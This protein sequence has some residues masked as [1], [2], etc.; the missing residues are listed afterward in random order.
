MKRSYIVLA[1]AML[2]ASAACADELAIYGIVDAGLA[3]YAKVGAGGGKAALLKLDTGV[4]QS[5]RLGLKGGEDL[6]AGQRAF[7]VVETGFTLD[8]GAAA[9][10]GL[11]FG[12][13]S[14]V[15]WSD[16]ALGSVSAGRQYDFMS[17]LGAQYAMAAQSPA[18]QL[19]WG[20]HADSGGGALD[21]RVHSG[22]R[23]N[24]AVKY[25]SAAIDGLS[26]G[27]MYTLGEVAGNARANRSVSARASY[28]GAALSV[29]V[30][31]TDLSN[32]T[33]PAST[34]IY[35]VGAR[36]SLGSWKPFAL[37]TRVRAGASGAV[38]TTGDIGVTYAMT[39]ALD[40]GLGYLRQDRNHQLGP[41]QQLTATLDYQLSRRT[42]AYL[43]YAYER[44]RARHAFPVSAVGPASSDGQQNVL[45]AGLRH[46][47]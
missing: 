33:G 26:W 8:D 35:G 1:A 28:D 46:L 12:R 39:A 7:F 44:D 9:Q 43:A 3:Y 15:G 5:N 14:L 18:G 32:A 24:N 13:Q 41:A 4:A 16:G 42:D 2:C 22:D 23:S 11:L 27:L 45:R 38:A 31:C 30:A 34:R 29:G 36:R 19:A 25:S 20:L 40:A 17:Q 6:G 37:L 47:F 21:D 10:G